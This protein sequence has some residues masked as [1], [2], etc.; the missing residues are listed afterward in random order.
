MKKRMV[1]EREIEKGE[2]NERGERLMK[3]SREEWRWRERG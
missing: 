3:E 1:S 2:E